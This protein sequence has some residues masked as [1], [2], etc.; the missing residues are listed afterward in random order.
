[1]IYT[2]I[3]AT[4]GLTGGR[5]EGETSSRFTPSVVTGWRFSNSV[6][7][8]NAHLSHKKHRRLDSHEDSAIAIMITLH[9]ISCQHWA[10]VQLL[11]LMQFINCRFIE[12]N[13]CCSC[14]LSAMFCMHAVGVNGDTI[15][16]GSGESCGGCTQHIFF[17]TMSHV[18]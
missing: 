15:R 5:R 6:H 10:A 18:E 4:L 3:K 16:P 17:A 2:A 14:V 7:A 12:L 13:L 11:S 9:S 1:M 8:A